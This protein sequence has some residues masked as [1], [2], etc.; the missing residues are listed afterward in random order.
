[1][2][3]LAAKTFWMSSSPSGTVVLKGDLD[4]GAVKTFERVM[5][6][7]IA[8]GGPVTVDASKL[9][10]IDSTGIRLFVHTARRLEPNG[11]LIVHGLRDRLRRTI[12]LVELSERVGNLHLVDHDHETAPH[13]AA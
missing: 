11:C 12:D 6:P 4:L 10:F 1:V 7:A 3:T 8:V 13:A 5:R 2:V 9:V